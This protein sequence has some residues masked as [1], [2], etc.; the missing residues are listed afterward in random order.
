MFARFSQFWI[1]NPIITIIFIILTIVGGALSWLIIP[2]QFN[3]D[4]SAPT[5]SIVMTAPGYSA[6][7]IYDYI[8]KPA[9]NILADMED[10]DHVY[11]TTKRDYGALT[12]SFK[13]GTDSEKAVTRLTNKLLTQINTKPDWV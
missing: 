13:A 8:V 1:K 12:V 4:I 7:Q 9:E 6:K 5:Y 3:P 2:K 10:L 11:S